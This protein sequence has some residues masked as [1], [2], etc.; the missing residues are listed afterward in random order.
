MIQI[1]NYL[2][3]VPKVVRVNTSSVIFMR[4]Y[5]TYLRYLTIHDCVITLHFEQQERTSSAD[6]VI[7]T[8][9]EIIG[10]KLPGKIRVHKLIDHVFRFQ[11][12]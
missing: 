11:M 9:D 12:H 5:L 6:E 8:C 7:S 1:V 2:G 4:S 3:K 10:T